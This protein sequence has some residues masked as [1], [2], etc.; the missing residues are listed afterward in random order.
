MTDEPTIGEVM[1]GLDRV[2]KALANQIGQLN[3]RLD[4]VPTDSLMEQMIATL[5]TEMRGMND[6]LTKVETEVKALD[7]RM[8]DEAKERDKQR[9]TALLAFA[10]SI[11][12]PVVVAV[13]IAI[14]LGGGAP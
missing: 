4:R 8:D 13:V 3:T 14:V 11:V 1:R 2:E 9:R 12:A 10:T 5:R 7:D 6:R